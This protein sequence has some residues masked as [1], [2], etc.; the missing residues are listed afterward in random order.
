[1]IYNEWNQFYFHYNY[2]KSTRGL[3]TYTRTFTTVLIGHSYE[4]KVKG[5]TA[6]QSASTYTN[7]V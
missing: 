7:R 6:L 5:I 2:D 4:F 1:M 3:R